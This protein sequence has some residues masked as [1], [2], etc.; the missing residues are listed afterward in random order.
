MIE[1]MTPD[2]VVERTIKASPERIY[3]ALTQPSE[4][5][6]WFFTEC[7]VSPA[8]AAVG[9]AYKH[10]WR[11]AKPEHSRFGRFLELIPGRKVVFEWRSEPGRA[12]DLSAFGDT[13]VTIT[14]TPEAQGTRV[15]LVH[16]GWNAAPG[17]AE[18][19]SGHE[20]GWTF[21]VENLE[22]YLTGGRDLRP[23]HHGQQ[24]TS[25]F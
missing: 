13:I 25:T 16:S 20:K 23:Q 14:L 21:Y 8:P 3:S 9:G 24:V 1:T 7:S 11:G 4:L 5:E 19:R 15:R 17:A 6:R 12:M 10:T 18:M 2:V 22:R